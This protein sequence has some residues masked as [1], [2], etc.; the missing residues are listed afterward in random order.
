M[1]RIRVDLPEPEGPMTTTTSCLAHLQVDVV[2]G[3]ERAEELVDALQLDD[4][5]ALHLG[6]I[7]EHLLLGVGHRVPTPSLLS[8]RWLS[9]DIVNDPT[10]NK[11]PMNTSDSM[12]QPLPVEVGLLG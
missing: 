11:N 6:G 1:Q 12:H 2:E 7:G 8:R 9:L 4:D 10:Q 3:L 5:V